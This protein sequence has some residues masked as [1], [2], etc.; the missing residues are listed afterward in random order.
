MNRFRPSATKTRQ[1][2]ARKHEN[3]SGRNRDR[4]FSDFPNDAVVDEALKT[5]TFPG[6]KNGVLRYVDQS[7]SL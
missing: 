1:D 4:S 3:I 6:G 7:N 5:M 2:V